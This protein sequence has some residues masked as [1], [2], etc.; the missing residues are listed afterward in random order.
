MAAQ[1]WSFYNKFKEFLGDATIDLDDPGTNFNLVLVQSSSNFATA[2][3]STYGSITNE[4]LS[5]NNY[6]LG[7]RALSSVTW[8][9]GASAGEMRWDSTAK[10][11]T[12]SGGTIANIKAAVIVAETGTSAQDGANKL[13]CYA[14]LTSAQFPLTDAN[15]LTITPS[16]NGIFE[17]N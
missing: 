10:I 8:A 11:Y 7:G 13:V 4:V 15:T 2:T 1:A 6:T 9:S 16:A 17:L 14:S 12:A 5:A 3:L